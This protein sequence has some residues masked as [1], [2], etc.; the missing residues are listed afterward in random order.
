MLTPENVHQAHQPHQPHQAVEKI[1]QEIMIQFVEE[2]AVEIK[3][4]LATSVYL[5]HITVNTL[6]KVMFC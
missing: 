1:A 5:R 6:A 2:I 3:K 4:H